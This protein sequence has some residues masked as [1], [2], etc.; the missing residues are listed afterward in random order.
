MELLLYLSVLLLALKETLSC[1]C[2]VS[3]SQDL[4]CR[5]DFILVATVKGQKIIYSRH[6]DRNELPMSNVDFVSSSFDS[7]IPLER[8]YRV[9]VHRTFKGNLNKEYQRALKKYLYTGGS[10]AACGVILEHRKTYLLSGTIRNNQLWINYCGWFQEY[11]TLN[12]QQ[13]KFLKFKYK[14]NCGC[15]VTSCYEG[16]YCPAAR[17]LFRRDYCKYQLRR[18]RTPSKDCFQRHGQCVRMDGACQWK[19]NKQF[20]VCLKQNGQSF[21]WMNR[22]HLP[23]GPEISPETSN[24]SNGHSPNFPGYQEP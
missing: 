10:D 3:H 22:P 24:E 5:S 7:R 14:H 6:E 8:H 21:P 13:K 9:R 4:Y 23:I 11:K 19:K 2:M 16:G 17:K 15:K 12:L 1:S 20:K 18:D